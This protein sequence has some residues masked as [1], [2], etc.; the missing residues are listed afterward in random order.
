MNVEHWWKDTD[1]IVLKYSN[2]IISQCHF[3]QSR[4]LM[5]FWDRI[6]SARHHFYASCLVHANSLTILS[7]FTFVVRSFV[8]NSAFWAV[9]P[10][11]V[12][13]FAQ[14]SPPYHHCI[15]NLI[16]LCTLLVCWPRADYQKNGAG[17]EADPDIFV[18]LK[19]TDGICG[20]LS[21]LSSLRGWGMLVFCWEKNSGPPFL[22]PILK[23]L[24]A[25]AT[26]I[27]ALGFKI[28][29]VHKLRLR[30]CNSDPFV[31]VYNIRVILIIKPTRC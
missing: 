8:P 18:P 9:Y 14:V 25:V 28:F 17:V 19:L 29:Y 5:H 12:L 31:T 23:I 30:T 27:L 1:R 4:D 21:I 13:R 20:P 16:A 3:V 24:T 7:I 6:F 11:T 15:T 26:F 22:V 10:L 2:R